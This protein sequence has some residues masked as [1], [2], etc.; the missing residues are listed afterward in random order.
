MILCWCHVSLMF[1]IAVFLSEVVVISSPYN[2]LQERNTFHQICLRILR[3]FHTCSG[4]TCLRFL[5]PF[6]G[7]ILKLVCFLLVL[8]NTRLNTDSLPFV[9]SKVALKLK[10][11]VSPWPTG[12]W[13]SAGFLHVLAVIC[14]RLLLLLS[15]GV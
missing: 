2:C 4:Y 11:V 5:V 15:L 14:Q 9:F 6:Y 12:I 1:Y 8:Q 10:F 3:L 7:R 13:A